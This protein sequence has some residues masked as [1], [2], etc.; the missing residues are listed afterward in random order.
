MNLPIMVS[1]FVLTLFSFGGMIMGSCDIKLESSLIKNLL[2]MVLKKDSD[3][4]CMLAS[5]KKTPAFSAVLTHKQ[6]ASANDVIKFNKVF[7]NKGKG[8]NPSTVFRLYLQTEG[9]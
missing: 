1:I 6:S 9:S 3:K 7:T 4:G 8:Y 2:E 5:G